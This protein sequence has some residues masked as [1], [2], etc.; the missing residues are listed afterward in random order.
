VQELWD[1]LGLLGFWDLMEDELVTSRLL[2]VPLS[3]LEITQMVVQ[4]AVSMEN[5]QSA[6]ILLQRVL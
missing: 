2:S 3:H 1:V 6:T 4:I 5:P